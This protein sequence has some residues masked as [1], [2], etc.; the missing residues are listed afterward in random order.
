M[1]PT[2]HRGSAH[3][4][5]QATGESVAV[6][7]HDHV[8]IEQGKERVEVARRSGAGG[9]SGATRS[10]RSSG[11]RSARTPDT[12]PTKITEHKSRDSPH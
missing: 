12:L 1:K 6:R 4:R 3:D 9:S 10:H 8:G 7:A 2:R 11:T 5:P